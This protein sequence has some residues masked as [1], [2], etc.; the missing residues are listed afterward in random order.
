MYE[1]IENLLKF[2]AEKHN[3]NFPDLYEENEKL[4]EAIV[5]FVDHA[6]NDYCKHHDLVTKYFPY[7]T[8]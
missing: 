1:Y 5:N 6:K 2:Y 8:Y 4:G 3:G 7:F